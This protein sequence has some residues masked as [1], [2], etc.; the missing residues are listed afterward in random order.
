MNN[1]NRHVVDVAQHLSQVAGRPAQIDGH[2]R[3]GEAVRVGGSSIIVPRPLP[4]RV[5]RNAYKREM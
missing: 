2:G 4:Q 1:Q 3:C 5:T